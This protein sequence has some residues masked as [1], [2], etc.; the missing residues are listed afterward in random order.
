MP[1]MRGRAALRGLI[2]WKE[3]VCC[4]EKRTREKELKRDHCFAAPRFTASKEVKHD[5]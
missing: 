5:A 3:T 1:L 2:E 4:T